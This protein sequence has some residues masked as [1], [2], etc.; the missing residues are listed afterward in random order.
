MS[1]RMALHEAAAGLG[2]TAPSVGDAARTRVRDGLVEGVASVVGTLAAGDP[3]EV[4]LPVLRRA[5]SCPGSVGLPDAPFSWK[6]VFARRSLGLAAVRACADGRFRGPAEA[7][8]P[9]AED[10]VDEWRRTGRR[11]FHWEPWFEGLGSGGRAVVLA[12]ATT[13][14]GPLW[15]AADWAAL[16]T[17][18]VLGGRDELW[19][20]PGRSAV[21]LKG[22]W[23]AKVAPDGSKG[24]GGVRPGA[25]T[26]LVSLSGGIPD[27]GW[28]D[29]LAFLALVAGLRSPD[30]PVPARVVGLWPEAGERRTVEVDEAALTD[31][32]ERVVA[33]VELMAAARAPGVVA[34]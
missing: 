8:G 12:E 25:G 1:D 32:A 10:A 3:V 21:R 27:E 13:W 11:T 15:V 5:R 28:A 24:G 29:D 20:C 14:A 9:L 30:L 6:P 23:E 2:V 7:V 18:A 19:T 26:A 17:R 33:A 31:A 34:A 4:T 16:G 22:R